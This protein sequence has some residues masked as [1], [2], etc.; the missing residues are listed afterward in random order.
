MLFD[1]FQRLALGLRQEEG[2]GEEV[3]HRATAQKK[4]M[5]A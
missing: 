4:N 3:D 1:L 5:A 2:G